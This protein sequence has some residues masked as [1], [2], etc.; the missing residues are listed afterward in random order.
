MLI[1]LCAFLWLIM[2]ILSFSLLLFEILVDLLVFLGFDH[3]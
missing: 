2:L 1:L 3:F